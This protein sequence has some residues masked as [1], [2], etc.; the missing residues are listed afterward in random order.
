MANGCVSAE[1]ILGKLDEHLHKNDYAAAE[2]HLS[3]W[4]SEA[5]AAKDVR[6]ELLIQN[7]RMGLYRKLSQREQALACASAALSVVEEQGISQMVGAATTLL[8]AATVYKAFGMAEDALPLFEQA[9]AVYER[10][11]A[12]DDTRLAGL[13][14]NMA[15]A[16][17]D[18]GRF[19]EAV[20]LYRQALQIVEAEENGAPEAAVTYLNIATAKEAELGS[21]AA[22]EQISLCLEKAKQLLEGYKERN[23]NYAFVCEKCASVFGYYGYFRYEKEL[24]E[25]ARRIYEGA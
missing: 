11:L 23:G 7:E 12:Q 19:Q 8:N 16:L 10:E 21:L 1:R 14:N 18:L 25:R 20:L 9:R 5:R 3:F 17:V 15:L 2:R 22:E 24:K 4:L 6:I 13:Y